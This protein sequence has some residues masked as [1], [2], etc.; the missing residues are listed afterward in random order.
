MEDLSFGL[1]LNVLMKLGVVFR[2]EDLSSGGD[3]LGVGERKAAD[4]LNR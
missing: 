1:T 3:R 2:R 4:T